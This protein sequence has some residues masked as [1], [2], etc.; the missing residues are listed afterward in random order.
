MPKKA[1]REVAHRIDRHRL[2]RGDDRLLVERRSGR[3]ERI[4]DRKRNA[5]E[6]LHA[7]SGSVEG[8]LLGVIFGA[9]KPALRRLRDVPHGTLHIP[10]LKLDKAL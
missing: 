9:S 1:G 5:E 7:L 4:P 6:S 10:K 3:V 2:G 8:T